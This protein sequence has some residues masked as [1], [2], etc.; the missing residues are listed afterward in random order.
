MSTDINVAGTAG[1]FFVLPLDYATLLFD[2][3][4]TNNDLVTHFS[5]DGDTIWITGGGGNTSLLGVPEPLTLSLFGVGL[6]GVAGLR[7]RRQSKKA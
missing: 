4:F 6:A 7:R 1:R 5:T 2:S 3:A